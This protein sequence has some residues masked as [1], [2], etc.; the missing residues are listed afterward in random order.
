MMDSAVQ[1]SMCR[2]LA[3]CEHYITW[4]NTG[5]FDEVL[6]YLPPGSTRRIVDYLRKMRAHPDVYAARGLYI[7]QKFLNTESILTDLGSV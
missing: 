4:D 3:C 2:L 1:F 6:Q 5:K 7:P